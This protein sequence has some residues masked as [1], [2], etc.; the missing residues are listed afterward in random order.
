[1]SL[2]QPLQF[3]IGNGAFANGHFPNGGYSCLWAVSYLSSTDHCLQPCEVVSLKSWQEIHRNH[4]MK[5]ETIKIALIL[6]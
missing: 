3:N 4:Y 2:I 1:M 5:P 6:T